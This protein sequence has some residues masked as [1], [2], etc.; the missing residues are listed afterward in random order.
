MNYSC[1]AFKKIQ[2]L[3]DFEKKKT[4]EAVERGGKKT[5]LAKT[6]DIP[7]STMSTN[8]KRQK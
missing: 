7:L 5:D 6:F 1:D 2:I 4:I 8:L 3:D